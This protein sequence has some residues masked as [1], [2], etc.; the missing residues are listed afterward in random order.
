MDLSD[1]GIGTGKRV[2]ATLRDLDSRIGG[3]SLGMRRRAR[4]PQLPQQGPPP[5][6]VQ[7]QQIMEQR[8]S[9]SAEPRYQKRPLDR[10]VG[11]SGI[12]DQVVGKIQ[13][14]EDPGEYFPLQQSQCVGVVATL[15]LQRRSE[16]SHALDV[17]I[18]RRQ[19]P[20]PQFPRGDAPEAIDIDR[21]IHGRS[22]INERGIVEIDR[23]KF[24][25]LD[26]LGRA[27]KGLG[28][29]RG[30]L[31]GPPLP[32]PQTIPTRCPGDRHGEFRILL[33][34]LLQIV[35][36]LHERILLKAVDDV[37]SA[38]RP[39]VG[40]E[41]FRFLS[42]RSTQLR[43]AHIGC[44]AGND[45]SDNPIL[46]VEQFIRCNFFLFAPPR[47]T[48]ISVATRIANIQHFL[49]LAH[50]AYRKVLADIAIWKSGEFP[51]PW[52]LV[53]PWGILDRESEHPKG[54][55]PRIQVPSVNVLS[56]RWTTISTSYSQP[57]IA[58]SSVRIIDA[59]QKTRGLGV[60][61][62]APIRSKRY[63]RLAPFGRTVCGSAT[64]HRGPANQN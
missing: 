20:G 4:W 26:G 22:I 29:I 58:V 25:L 30:R 49:S 55:T 10:H 17:K 37:Q 24:V 34:R 46:H 56:T 6:R 9:G 38:Q 8:A 12:A 31:S 52:I 7:R 27:L 63:S 45:L 47:R 60:V 21:T 53:N 50:A 35:S 28:A 62:G 36:R 41:V 19:R 59:A 61:S 40:A 14:G 43:S 3:V 57:A 51:G 13:I 32:H 5:P 23:R 39:V 16:A 44:D 33:H 2:E 11:N 48:R 1:Q 54:T 15:A 18:V 42:H 64:R